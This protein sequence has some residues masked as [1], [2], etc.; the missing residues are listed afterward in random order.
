MKKFRSLPHDQQKNTQDFYARVYDLV[1]LIPPGKVCTY[2]IIAEFLGAKSSSRMVG[3]ALN[4]VIDRI[5][6]PCHRVVN[7][8]GD[9]T[10]KLHFAYPEQMKELLLS[11]NIQFIGESVD[12][13]KHLWNPRDQDLIT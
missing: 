9:L 11:E 13:L 10:G 8:N 3:W 2:G 1:R 4:C 6:I 12:I 7:R 5:D